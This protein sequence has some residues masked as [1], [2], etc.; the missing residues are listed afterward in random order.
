M[1]IK[2]ATF[3]IGGTVDK[4]RQEEI[5][6]RLNDARE[7]LGFTQAEFAN[8]IGITRDRLATY[9]DGRTPLRCD[10]ALKACRHFFISEFW[11]ASGAVSE[12]DLKAGRLVRFTELDARLTM[13]LGVNPIAGSFPFGASFAE[14]FE[15]HLRQAYNQQRESWQD[16]P[17]VIP[18]PTDGAEYLKHAVLCMMEFWQRGISAPNFAGLVV[19]VIGYG[20]HIYRNEF[21]GE[22]R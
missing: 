8:Q 18:L 5:S 6:F 20:K 17:A 11:L 1:V 10:V 13:A 22:K 15:P 21:S 7:S 4:R 12:T 3:E 14:C 16:L 19:N 9:E 2:R